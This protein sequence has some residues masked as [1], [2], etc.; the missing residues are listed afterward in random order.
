MEKEKEEEEEVTWKTH[1][2]SCVRGLSLWMGN[3]DSLDAGSHG[4]S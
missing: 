4:W 2:Y 1:D 3:G